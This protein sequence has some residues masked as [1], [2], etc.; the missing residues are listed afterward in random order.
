MYLFALD[1]LVR[2]IIMAKLVT[3]YY[4]AR[5]GF[6]GRY[7]VSAAWQLA[8]WRVRVAGASPKRKRYSCV[9]MAPGQVGTRS[10]ATCRDEHLSRDVLRGA[11][12]VVKTAWDFSCPRLARTPLT[13]SADRC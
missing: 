11:D 6:V 1:F 9:P 4:G 12:A 7:I 10:F 13:H 3:V 2:G 8:G 5:S